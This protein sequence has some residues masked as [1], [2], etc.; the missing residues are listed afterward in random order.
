LSGGGW[1]GLGVGAGTEV[2]TATMP[3]YIAPVFHTCSIA[4]AAGSSGRTAAGRN[5]GVYAGGE[6]KAENIY[7]APGELLRALPPPRTSCT[8]RA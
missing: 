7:T 1:R 2:D 3:A 6:L 4:S 5:N 8:R